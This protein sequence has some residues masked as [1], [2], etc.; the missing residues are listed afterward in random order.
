MTTGLSKLCQ[1]TILAAMLAISVVGCSSALAPA[2]LIVSINATSTQGAL[3]DFATAVTADTVTVTGG[4]TAPSP[5]Y[6][7]TASVVGKDST[8]EATIA[9]AAN[10]AALC[11][12]IV[13]KFA[14]SLTIAGVPTGTWTLRVRDKIDQGTPTTAFE[15]TI[16]VR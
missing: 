5:C 16:Q 11:V 7:F 1:V 15:T 4:L 13:G 2:N 12:A 10:P 8:I 9:A 14:Y 6:L 3:P